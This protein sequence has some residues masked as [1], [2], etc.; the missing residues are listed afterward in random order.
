PICW[1][2]REGDVCRNRLCNGQEGEVFIERI[3]A[4]TLFVDPLPQIV[5]RYKYENKYGWAQIF[6]R[7]LIGHLE[8]H[9]NL[10]DVDLIVANPSGSDRDHIAR[11]L[12][13]AR[14]QDFLDCALRLLRPE[15]ID[16]KQI[17]IYDDICTTGLQ[18]NAV[19][20]LLREWG[21]ESVCGIV[22]A[23]QPWGGS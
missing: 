2:E 12:K 5:H 18:L 17:V 6:A 16:G 15:L 14:V 4:I 3:E 10:A 7:L 20:R 23:R 13:S 8:N 11:V 1:Q 9:W 22:L 19:A 21:A